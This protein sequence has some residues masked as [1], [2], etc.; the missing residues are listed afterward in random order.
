M[1]KEKVLNFIKGERLA[2]LSTVTPDNKSESAV[3]E[4]GETDNLEIIFDT[5][6]TYRKYQNLQHNQN[7]SLVIGWD[8]EITVQYEGVA[9]ELT[10]EEEIKKYQQIYFAKNPKAEKFSKL[11]EIRYFV[12]E[13]TW[14]RYSN[15][16]VEPWEVF[17]I[18]F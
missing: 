5:F 14:I 4:F 13:P 3:L 12:V 11:P 17:E 15:L 9:R 16:G 18:K 2:V 1:E 8:D 6:H 7:V 10:S